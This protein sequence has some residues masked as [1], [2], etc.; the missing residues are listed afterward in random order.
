MTSL[1]T[2]PQVYVKFADVF[3]RFFFMQNLCEGLLDNQ[4]FLHILSTK[5]GSISLAWWGPAICDSILPLI[6]NAKAKRRSLPD[7][8]THTRAAD[9]RANRGWSRQRVEWWSR[10][11]MRRRAGASRGEDYRDLNH[12]RD[13]IFSFSFYW[14]MDRACKLLGGGVGRTDES[15][16]VDRCVWRVKM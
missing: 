15:R 7:V 4:F 5:L 3:I 16:P 2:T 11:E 14:W 13:S 9:G 1:R 10:L 8:P 12:D 6:W